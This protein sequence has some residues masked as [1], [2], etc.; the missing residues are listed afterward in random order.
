MYGV[1]GEAEG[2]GRAGAGF[3]VRERPGAH[4]RTSV[5]ASPLF[6]EAVARLL[7]YVDEALARPPELTVVD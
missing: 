4:F 3:F 2:G 7:L 1:G 6:A 5:H